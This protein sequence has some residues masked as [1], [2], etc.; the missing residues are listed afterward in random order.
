MGGGGTFP[1][2]AGCLPAWLALLALAGCAPEAAGTRDLPLA[3]PAGDVAAET[4][5]DPGAFADPLPVDPSAGDAPA[6]DSGGDVADDP[7]GSLPFLASIEPREGPAGTT[8]TVTVRGEGFVEGMEFLFG[9]RKGL[10][11]FVLSSRVANVTAPAAE[12]G[13]VDVRAVLPDGA[14][15]RL[16]RAFE[17]RGVLRIDSATPA[18]GLS[19]GGT[20]VTVRG[21]GFLQGPAFLFGGR[22]APVAQV[23]DDATAYVITPPGD[24]GLV[25]VVVLGED[26][27]ATLPDGFTYE[28]EGVP[29]SIES[30]KVLGCSPS[31][32]PPGGGTLL[33]LA[34][35]GFRADAAVRVGALPATGVRV[36]SDT[37]MEVVTPPGSPG[38]ARILVRQGTA[39]A[40]LD[41]A[42]E[43]HAG[44]G[45]TIL[46]VSPDSGSWSGGTRV[47]LQ[48]RNLSGV[49]KV[50]FGGVEA[51]DVQVVSSVRVDV[52]SPRASEPGTVPI[53]VLGDGGALG[54]AFTYFDPYLPGG[55]TWGGPV[56]GALN[57]MVLNSST[58]KA[59]RDAYVIVGADPHTPYQ[60]RTD[61]RGQI[62]LSGED[63][64]GPLAVTVGKESFTAATLAGFD[65][66]NATLY[67]AP[68]AS[69][70]NP[71]V[72]PGSTTASATCRVR[73]RVKDYGKYLVKPP[74]VEGTPYVQCS[75]SSTSMFGG[76]VDPGP[77]AAP[78]AQGRFEI[79]ARS[80]T[81]AVLCQMLVVDPSRGWAV[82]LRAGLARQVACKSGDVVEGIEVSIDRETDAD[83][84]VA[85][86]T[87]P[88]H[89]QGAGL[90]SFAGGWEL[91]E[92]GWLMLLQRYTRKATRTQFTNQPRTFDPPFDGRGYSY[93]VTTS[94]AT[95]IGIPYSTV[96]SFQV[97]PAG[98][99]P[100]LV[101]DGAG[102][103]VLP[104]SLRRE[105]TAV[106]PIAGGRA[107][108]ADAG[109][110]TWEF[111][112][113]A[114]H[115][116]PYRTS[117]AIFGLYG[118]DANDFWVVGARGMAR[119][120]V[121]GVATDVPAPVT[122]DFLG[123]S[124]EG[125]DAVS[126]A[127]GS[128]LLRLSGGSLVPETLPAGTDAKAVRRFPGGEIV[129]AGAGGAVVTGRTGEGFGVVRPI[130]RD[131][132]AVAGL[133]RDEV[134]I[135]GDRGTV[136]R[137]GRDDLTAV[138]APGEPDLAG[139]VAVGP[140]N[141]LVFGPGGVV[142]QYDGVSFVDRS[143]RDL[144]VDLMA[145][146]SAGG[147]VLL[148]GRHF[149]RLPSFLPFPE[150]LSPREA[151][152]WDH[153]RVAWSLG[154]QE[155][156][157]S[158]AQALLSAVGGATFW[159]VTAG[160]DV[161]EVLLPDLATVLGTDPIPAGGKRMNLTVVRAPGFDI[162]AYGYQDMGFYQREAY[163]VALT[164]FP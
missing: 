81:F 134:W 86:G 137:L 82:P 61:A 83:L 121:D 107:L 17:Y 22:E 118:E 19:G 135:V 101:E 29:P 155:S 4:P 35:T 133:D 98:D 30:F 120:V 27:S 50:F 75:I 16:P 26:G 141:V 38:P 129:A 79:V 53:M 152:V 149:V 109:G 92:D 7:G 117:R 69:P 147:R 41:G 136:I 128:F 156:G 59:L 99:W 108:A 80:G 43:Y 112:G 116:G 157:P 14:T 40:W 76:A 90:P 78:D 66:Q 84:W 55:G 63:L 67:I 52:R 18:T 34:G 161:R 74:W 97:P 125:P 72:P 39:G 119:H 58:G 77:K 23:A 57:V 10:Y 62:T 124:G 37:A 163:S 12:A 70:E 89:P 88:V 54:A 56:R 87:A 111:D 13:V 104:T 31:S 154:A 127:A 162:D 5:P 1:A 131:L 36:L 145:G 65:A 144:D 130:A 164:S 138:T 158:F 122:S 25:P 6:P 49:K 45:P 103:A 71:S 123:V 150:V 9:S 151:M 2:R 146:A 64:R 60:G 113:T 42:F 114:F 153:R 126:V 28:D 106:I 94:A 139:A 47:R 95:P 51:T 91:G 93:Y 143:R 11:P 105:I 140:G 8:T 46:A 159:V 68:A 96:L 73:G 85:T 115:V 100:V 24:P 44:A 142:M 132:R 48:G 110:S 102:F 21:A 148:A 20:P 33:S 32:G 15:A 160:G 3:D